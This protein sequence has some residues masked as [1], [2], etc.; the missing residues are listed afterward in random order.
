MN[1]SDYFDGS[2]KME[3]AIRS[4]MEGAANLNEKYFNPPKGGSFDKIDSYPVGRCGEGL[5]AGKNI[6]AS[7]SK[8]I[9]IYFCTK[10]TSSIL[11]SNNVVAYPMYAKTK[12]EGAQKSQEI[13]YPPM[14]N[15]KQWMYIG[16]VMKLDQGSYAIYMSQ[17]GNANTSM[18]NPK[19]DLKTIGKLRSSK[20]DKRAMQEV[21]NLV[22]RNKGSIP[23]RVK[24]EM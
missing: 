21:T 3:Q 20:F 8:D 23:S 22:S 14:P 10:R 12:E 6:F 9:E 17:S 7:S 18:T 24:S 16:Y 13:G 5:R 1:T 2:R 11:G 19:A 4:I 15:E